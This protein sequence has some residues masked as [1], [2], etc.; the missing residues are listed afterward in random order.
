ML[1]DLLVSLNSKGVC[2][3]IT[4]AVEYI[5]IAFPIRSTH[6]DWLLCSNE[7]HPIY[8]CMDCFEGVINSEEIF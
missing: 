5:A 1:D 8:D 2:C 7:L 4:S 3:L 6:H